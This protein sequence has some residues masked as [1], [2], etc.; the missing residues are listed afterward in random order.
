LLRKLQDA[1]KKAGLNV[2]ERVSAKIFAEGNALEIIKQFSTDLTKA[3]SLQNLELLPDNS[4]E[5]TQL[6]DEDIWY[7]F[8]D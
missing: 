3:A 1:R 7:K 8:G 5:L 2:G 6:P 4:E